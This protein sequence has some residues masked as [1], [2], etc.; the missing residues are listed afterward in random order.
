VPGLLSASVSFDA[1]L[2][3]AELCGFK[4]PFISAA[5]GF[6]LPP[7]AYPPA[8]PTFGLSLGLNCNLNNPISVTATLFFRGPYGGGR[9]P[10]YDPDPDLE[11]DP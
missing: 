7:L 3:A 5:L 8:I 11:F 4:I 6:H 1:G 10:A 2:P 9:I